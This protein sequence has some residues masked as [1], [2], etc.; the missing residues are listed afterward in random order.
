MLDNR[1]MALAEGYRLIQAAP[2]VK[3]YLELR[4]DRG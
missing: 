4:S 1:T 2:E 3:E